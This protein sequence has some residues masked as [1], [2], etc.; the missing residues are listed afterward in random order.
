MRGR[1]PRPIEIAPGDLPILQQIAR[2]QSRPWYQ[3][4]RARIL[5]GIADGAQ[6]QILAFLTQCDESTVRRTCRRY[7]RLGLS[8]LLE[9]AKRSGRPIVISP[10]G[11]ATT[12]VYRAQLLTP[13]VSRCPARETRLPEGASTP[14][15]GSAHTE[16]HHRSG[17]FARPWELRLPAKRKA[18][19]R[20]DVIARPASQAESQ[21][22]NEA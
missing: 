5:L 22:S 11:W 17:F 2:S 4:R 8:G 7:E 16:P 13:I 15:N 18:C 1:K 6:T 21:H 9:S 20:S 3:V 10:P 12:Q 14:P 19:Q